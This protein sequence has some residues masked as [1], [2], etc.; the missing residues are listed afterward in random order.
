[1]QTVNKKLGCQACF[2]ASLSPAVPQGS[3]SFPQNQYII[4]IRFPSLS[5]EWQ[6]LITMSSINIHFIAAG[7]IG[8]ASQVS[9]GGQ[10]SIFKCQVEKFPVS[11]EMIK[12]LEELWFVLWE[13]FMIWV[14]KKPKKPNKLK[15]GSYKTW[16]NRSPFLL[17]LLST[18]EHGT[19]IWHNA[20]I[21]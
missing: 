11:L 5:R 1:M 8:D 19:E 20:Q 7:F 3:V 13:Y 4:L 14:P 12:R 15:K 18:F 21:R 16:E 2:W 6:T 9:S 17:L 10:S